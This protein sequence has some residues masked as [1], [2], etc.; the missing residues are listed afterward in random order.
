MFKLREGASL[1][2]LSPSIPE[3]EQVSQTLKD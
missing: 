3:K 2:L 1:P